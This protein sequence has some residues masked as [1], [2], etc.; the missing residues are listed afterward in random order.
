[1]L[2][3]LNQETNQRMQKSI[4]AFA[5]T[6]R[7]IRTG[8]AT[9]DILDSV[10]IDYYG[11][12]TPINQLANIT[13]EDSQT[14]AISPWEQ[15]F[16]PEIEH[17]IVKANLGLNPVTSGTVIRIPLPHLTEERRIELTKQVRHEEEQSKVSIRNIRRDSI[18]D[19]RD[20]LNEK[21]ISED[22]FH[23]GQIDIQTI[24]DDMIK[25]IESLS[26]QKQTE[27]MSF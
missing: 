14:L 18:Q 12:E 6:L 23:K 24:T 17:A 16:I 27:L 22:D 21:I 9:P 8:R 4:D 25:K 19:L 2:D 1:M 10:L 7:R 3:E 5:S 15:K 13:V 11:S 26:E 20:F